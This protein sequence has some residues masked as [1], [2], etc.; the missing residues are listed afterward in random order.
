M[1]QRVVAHDQHSEGAFLSST[2]EGVWGKSS[3]VFLVFLA[4]SVILF[5]LFWIVIVLF[6]VQ[7][8]LLTKESSFLEM[9]ELDCPELSCSF[10]G[11]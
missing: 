6:E 5:G 11:F 10:W 1:T 8:S 3:Q 9:F 7:L 2:S 4:S